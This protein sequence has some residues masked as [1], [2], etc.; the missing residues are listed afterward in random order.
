MHVEQTKI[1][2]LQ[3]S[4]RP[5]V[6]VCIL[7]IPRVLLQASVRLS[8]ES[9]RLRSAL[10]GEF[11]FCLRGQSIAEQLDEILSGPH[12]R[13]ESLIIVWQVAPLLFRYSF[14]FT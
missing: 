13:A 11:P 9:G 14:L 10:T 7:L 8:V 1:V 2:G 3:T 6:V 4:H 12:F 5:R